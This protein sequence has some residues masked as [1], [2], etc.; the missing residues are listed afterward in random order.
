PETHA[1]AA[2]PRMVELPT[3]PIQIQREQLEL[4]KFLGIVQRKRALAGTSRTIQVPLSPRRAS[5]RSQG[6]CRHVP[7]DEGQLLQ[8]HSILAYPVW[9]GRRTDTEVDRQIED[10][11]LRN[12]SLENQRSLMEQMQVII[13]QLRRKGNKSI[14][15]G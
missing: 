5:S 6:I 12:Q 10:F 2:V 9:L 11:Q 1:E 8:S 4:G 14:V 15:N 3:L 7:S 13:E